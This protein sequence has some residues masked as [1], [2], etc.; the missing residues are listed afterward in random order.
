MVYKHPQALPLKAPPRNDL[1]YGATSRAIP[2]PRFT[3]IYAVYTY[4]RIFSAYI[5]WVFGQ[6]RDEKV[7]W[8]DFMDLASEHL[9][10]DVTVKK[11]R[12][13]FLSGQ[14]SAKYAEIRQNTPKYADIR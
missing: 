8:A 3:Q 1:G 4:I 10:Y 14:I 7:D 12:K 13:K 5:G 2:S 6:V 9:S 11:S